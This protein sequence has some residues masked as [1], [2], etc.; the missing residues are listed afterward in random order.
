MTRTRTLPLIPALL[1]LTLF[2]TAAYGQA[3]GLPEKQ[4]HLYAVKDTDSLRVDIYNAA[5]SFDGKRPCVV[6]MFGG[7]FVS[8]T[9][10]NPDYLPFFKFFNDN[11]YTVA[12]IDYRLGLK[13]FAQGTAPLPEG[14][15]LK[16]LN[17]FKQVLSNTIDIAVE[18]L[19]DATAFLMKNASDWDIDTTSLVACG[20]SA[21]AVAVLQGGYYINNRHVL[22]TRLP[23]NFNFAGVIAFAGAIYSMEGDLEWRSQPCPI[24]MYHGDS[25]SNVPYGKIKM[26]KTGFY[27]SEYIAGK[28]K[29][30]NYPYYFFSVENAA[31]EI[32]GWPMHNAYEQTLG[33][34]RNFVEKR[35]QISVRTDMQ[36][37]GRP[38]KQKKFR[39]QDYIKSNYGN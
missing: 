16:Q 37:I 17:Y 20:S 19:F 24:M 12:S 31:H 2:C 34:L 33:F 7:G 32:A 38:E 39:I 21:G 22:S 15:K 18:D 13:P 25:D 35:E 10:D 28:L 30:G 1:F 5:L 11:G 9:R 27:G 14:G 6:F 4:T 29:E 36:F 8:G 23:E 3:S 26:G